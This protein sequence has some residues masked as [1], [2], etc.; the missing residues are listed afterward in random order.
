MKSGPQGGLQLRAFKLT[1]TFVRRIVSE[2]PPTKDTVYADQDVPRHYIRVRPPTQ[3]DKPWPAESRIRYTLPGGHRRWLTTGNPRTMDLAALRV[4]ARAALAIADAGGDPAAQ[5]AAQRAAW[6]VR[7]LWDAYRTSPDFARCTPRVR[8]VATAK[9]A[10][11]IV[12]RIG[13]ERLVAID[14][15]LILR[16]IRLISTDTRVNSYKRRLGGPGAA[17]KTVRLLSGA[18]TWAV[19]EGQLER[20]PLRGGA[21][22]LD[23]DGVRE[24]VITQPQEYVA[25]FST[26]DGMVGQGTLRPAVRA[27]IIVAA[28]CGMR[29]G[30]LQ[31]LTWAQ[32]DLAQRR[33]TLN[34]AKGAKLARRGVKSETVSLP[35]LAATALADIRPADAL[36]DDQVFPP[37]RGRLIEV[38]RYWNRVRDAAGLP[39]D[40][41]LHGLRHSLGTAAVLSGLSGF[42]VQSLLR[43][44]SAAVTSRYVHLAEIASSRLQDRATERLTAGLGE[45]QP[46][47]EVLPLPRP[48]PSRRRA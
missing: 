6:T 1:Q 11:H 17:R 16:L 44:R 36:P 21:L 32:V 48:T 30:E 20:N 41:T 3:H 10:L 8:E 26:M 18:L 46:S 38:N 13:N 42:E 9:F 19:G 15:P 5:R 27:F 45:A 7:D 25:L 23:G 2:I 29:R 35:P 31:T 37:R 39:A 47:S 33:I 34:N 12:P 22:R 40:L 28:L 43:H 14:V 24:T 4:A